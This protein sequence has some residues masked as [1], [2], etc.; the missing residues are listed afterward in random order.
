[1][2]VQIMKRKDNYTMMLEALIQGLIPNA[3][4]PVLTKIANVI[5]GL[6]LDVE[7]F[8][9]WFDA[10]LR[11]KNLSLQNIDFV[12][13]LYQYLAYDIKKYIQ[14]QYQEEIPELL[15]HCDDEDT[16]FTN[17]Q[18]LLRSFEHLEKQNPQA[19]KDGFIKGLLAFYG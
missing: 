9:K 7:A 16:N 5:Q 1:M 14:E 6:Q 2:L 8:G 18:E 3:T 13:M 10:Q 4:L 15:I 12:C 19:S 11:I 17:W